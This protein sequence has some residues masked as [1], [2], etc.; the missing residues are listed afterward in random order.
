[1]KAP[2]LSVALREAL[3]QLLVRAEKG[4]DQS[5]THDGLQNCQA[6]AHARAVLAR[7][8]RAIPKRRLAH[9]PYTGER[10]LVETLP[11][12]WKWGKF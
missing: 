12:G 7:A 10:A 8:C 9:S 1:V 11:V 3:A 4:L 6:I 5:P 2:A